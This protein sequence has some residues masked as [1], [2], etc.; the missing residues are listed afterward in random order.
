MLSFSRLTRIAAT[1]LVASAL[2]CQSS[3]APVPAAD[4]VVVPDAVPD[5]A[6]PSAP[7]TVTAVGAD[8]LQMW[9]VSGLSPADSL[10]GTIDGGLGGRLENAFVRLDIPRG[11]FRGSARV[12]V[13]FPDAQHL[14][15]EL[16][17]EPATLNQFAQP[18]ELRL[19]TGTCVKSGEAGSYWW[20]PLLS[21]WFGLKGGV[22]DVHGDEVR[23]KL[24]HFSKYVVGTKA[25]W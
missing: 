19:R 12:S 22:Y 10:V 5:P 15:A 4:L 16:S 8:S 18:V 7:A 21:Q 13:H 23:V 25:G 6:H 11:A 17:I 1:L 24:L 14:V 3:T 20:D 9:V 2:G